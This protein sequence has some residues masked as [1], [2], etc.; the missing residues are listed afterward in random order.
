MDTHDV[1]LDVVKYILMAVLSLSG[2]IAAIGHKALIS[3]ILEKISS[4]FVSKEIYDRDQQHLM[5][6]LELIK[7]S[8]SALNNK[9]D[10]LMT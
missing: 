7:E 10:R 4:K 8:I 1:F 6:S 3:S 5:Q 2:W 9:I